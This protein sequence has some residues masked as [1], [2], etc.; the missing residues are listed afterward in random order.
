M[1]LINRTPFSPFA[2][3]S[4]DLSGGAFQVVVLK[5]TFDIVPGAPPALAS[6]QEPVLT[7]EE[8]HDASSPTSIRAEDDLAPFKPRTDI[9]VTATS[10]APRN[11]PAREW[12]AG[13]SLG[14]VQKRVLVTGLRVWTH[15]TLSGWSLGAPIPTAAVPLRYD[16]AFGGVAKRRNGDEAYRENPVGRGF[17]DT[18][19]ADTSKPIAAPTIL[20]PDFRP[21]PLGGRYPVEG[22]SAIHRSWQP[23][24][25][26]AGTLDSAWAKA[27]H[28][29][30]PEDFDYAFYNC[31]H[32]DLIYP[33]YV[34][35]GEEV[36]LER[37]CREHEIV[38]FRL[39]AH[40][41][42]VAI[43]DKVGYRYGGAA[44][45][46]TVHIDTERMKLLLVFRATLPLFRDGVARIDTAITDSIDAIVR[47]RRDRTREAR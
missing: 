32:P 5:G 12:L 36:R 16:C 26:K 1:K 35:G 42:G 18:E 6:R 17:V 7:E 21:P 22:L 13:V 44:R 8:P 30:Q 34:G 40:V 15:S 2:F 46:D 9:V 45:L 24:L 4:L 38:C 39:P 41:V 31:A 43:T 10:Y 28:P 47:A 20:T 3:Q 37:L 14:R 33:G 29:R 27:R 19:M 25:A 23:R 11:E